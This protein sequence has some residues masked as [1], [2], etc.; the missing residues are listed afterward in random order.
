[1]EGGRNIP[2]SYMNL[3]SQFSNSSAMRMEAAGFHEIMVIYGDIYSHCYENPKY[4]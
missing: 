2:T 1:V 4:H 3:L